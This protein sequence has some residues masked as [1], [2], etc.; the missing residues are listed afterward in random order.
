MGN[1]DYIE[2]SPGLSSSELLTQTSPLVSVK[3]P[4][5]QFIHEVFDC[6]DVEQLPALSSCPSLEEI[7]EELYDEVAALFSPE[8]PT[9]NIEEMANAIQIS[10]LKTFCATAAKFCALNKQTDP[11]GA[12]Y[13]FISTWRDEYGGTLIHSE[14]ANAIQISDLKTFC[15]TAAKFC[16]LN[17]QA[18]PNGAVYSFIS[19][20]RDE[21]GGTLIH[22][23][24]R[25][26]VFS[27][28]RNFG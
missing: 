17:K 11:N 14:M 1:V 22:S 5:S 16:A 20:W 28:E 26:H 7:H 21:Y 3:V 4:P 2:V 27:Y 9:F 12:V 19:T 6:N 13:S 24:W 23:V 25:L 10:D 15:A 18:D 8:Q